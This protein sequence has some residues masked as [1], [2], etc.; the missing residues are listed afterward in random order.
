MRLRPGTWVTRIFG[1]A[2]RLLPRWFRELYGEDMLRTFAERRSTIHEASGFA[3]ALVFTLRSLA[4][5][6]GAALAARRQ[7]RAGSPAKGEGLSEGVAGARRP[8]TD[9][10]GW[11]RGWA[12]DGRLA[13]RSL[14]A[15]PVAT[16]AVLVTVALAVGATTVVFSVVNGVLLRPLP[17][18]EPDRLV[19]IWQ[20]KGEW[21][22]SPNSQLRNFATRFPL[23]VPTF[24]DWT[25]AETGF[26]ALGAY[27]DQLWVEHSRTV[28]TSSG[29]SRPRPASSRRWE[30]RRSWDGRSCRRTT[31]PGR[32]GWPY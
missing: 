7:R 11:L 25:R 10:L 21:M 28:R 31:L 16:L 18:P 12:H 24:E 2:L 13:M 20:T 9:G 19:R 8:V 23:S 4:D 17:Y 1:L 26:E 29:A 27:R 22:S 30:S 6:P 15:R 5:I 3:A 32:R 14:R